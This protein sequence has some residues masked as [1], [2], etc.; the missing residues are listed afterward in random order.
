MGILTIDD[1]KCY[2]C[3]D[4]LNDKN[5]VKEPI[6]ICELG[7]SLT[8]NKLLCKSCKNRLDEY[9]D[10]PFCDYINHN[11]SI[12]NKNIINDFPK[13]VGHELELL[14]M[15]AEM[16]FLCGVPYNLLENDTIP[17]LRSIVENGNTGIT[18]FAKN[19]SLDFVS[20][21]DEDD[22]KTDSKKV[23]AK[24]YSKDGQIF[25]S[26]SIFDIHTLNVS[27]SN[28][29]PINLDEPIYYNGDGNNFYNY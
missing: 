5:T 14:K 27:L 11:I 13:F 20:K 29:F 7:E 1:N 6:F 23:N 22:V 12:D 26:I 17:V 16:S 2:I 4:F 28:N 24:L 3:H 9:L 10:K 21:Y 19:N 8:S 25:C 15:S 18:N